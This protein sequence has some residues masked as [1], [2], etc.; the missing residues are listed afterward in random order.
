MQLLTNQ[1]GLYH[2]TRHGDIDKIHQWVIS[3]REEAIGDALICVAKDSDRDSLKMLFTAG[4]NINA[5][6]K[7]GNTGLHVATKLGNEKTIKGFIGYSADI[8]TKNSAGLTP[9][10]LA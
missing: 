1:Q 2:L 6:D 4:A 9:L 3:N 7:D 5:K 10:H 8:N